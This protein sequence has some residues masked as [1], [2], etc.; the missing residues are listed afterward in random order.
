MPN[1][2]FPAMSL[3]FAPPPKRTNPAII[4]ASVVGAVL[5]AVILAAVAI[6]V[7]LSQQKPKPVTLT[8][9]DTLEGSPRVT[10]SA[11]QQATSMIMQGLTDNERGFATDFNAALYAGG[12]SP[13]VLVATGKLTRRPTANNRA[14]F[15][16]GLERGSA[17]SAAPMS[18]AQVP[19]GP[20]GGTTECGLEITAT[21][22]AVICLS[23]D[24]SAIVFIAVYTSDVAG[25]TMTAL[26]VRSDVEHK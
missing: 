12:T 8:I 23:M 7:F 10:S 14:R 13:G 20:L 1:P 26:Q 18:F 6:P 21:T 9:P 11:A 3:P 19:P 16:Q 4:I 5:L 22:P 24:D 15:F 25:G 2:A 17:S